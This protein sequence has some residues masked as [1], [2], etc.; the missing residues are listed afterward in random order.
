MYARKHWERPDWGRRAHGAPFSEELKRTCGWTDVNLWVNIMRL[1]VLE[2]AKWT[3]TAAE[4]EK[5]SGGYG[6]PLMESL[7]ALGSNHEKSMDGLL[8]MLE[9]FSE[10][11]Q[12]MLH[13]GICHE[14]DEN[15]KIFEFIKGDLRLVW[16]YGDGGKIIICSHCFVKKGQ[17]TP[18]GEK[19]HAISIKRQYW[20][21]R[22]KGIAVPLHYEDEE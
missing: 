8:V 3:V 1:L 12:K 20:A 2:Q 15:E 17:K 13:D 10:H 9:R 5:P 7:D 6:C 14:I 21:L 16:F 4:L 22:D 19:S 18:N 11:G